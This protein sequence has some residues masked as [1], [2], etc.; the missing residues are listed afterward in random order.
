MKMFN[1]PLFGV[2]AALLTGGLLYLSRDIG[3]YGPLVLIAPAPVLVYAL[4]STQVWR[5]ALAA[6]VA[7]VLGASALVQ[8]YG[9]I[10]PLPAIA[11]MVGVFAAGFVLTVLLTPKLR[12]RDAR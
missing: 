10:L 5:V 8:A 6:L 3:E 1:H 9:G 12:T 2:A 4:A 11:I 7:R